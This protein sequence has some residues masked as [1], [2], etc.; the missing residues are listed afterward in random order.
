MGQVSLLNN[1]S[2]LLSRAPEGTELKNFDC[3]SSLGSFI[4]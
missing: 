1:W 3:F 4:P 2:S